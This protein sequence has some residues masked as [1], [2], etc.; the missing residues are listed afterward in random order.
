MMVLT[1]LLSFFLARGDEAVT[2][3]PVADPAAGQPAKDVQEQLAQRMANDIRVVMN[4]T[5]GIQKTTIYENGKVI[6]EFKISG[7]K[8]KAIVVKGQRFCAFTT[9]G[10]N[11]KP[12]E[13]L[14]QRFS[15]E[16]DLN[17]PYFVTFDYARGIGAHSGDVSGYSSG[18]VRQTPAGAKALYDIVKANSTL[19]P[20]TAKIEK[21]NVRLDVIDNTPGRYTA[22]CG[23]LKRHMG[24][25]RSARAQRVCALAEAEPKAPLVAEKPAKK[26]PKKVVAV[27]AKPAVQ[28]AQAPTKKPVKKRNLLQ[29][30]QEG[31]GLY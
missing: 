4:I 7:S 19:R 17:L 12:Q 23:C 11:I 10:E 20:G 15:R 31:N 29:I 3:S 13:V 21:T 26:A 9:T 25:T 18:C 1:I 5:R 28:T 8:N 22:E 27:A 6:K 2:T 24:D 16:H 30:I 14:R